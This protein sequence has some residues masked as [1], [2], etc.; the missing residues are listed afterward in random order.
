MRRREE[1]QGD[2]R[3]LA[4]KAS[5]E[6]QERLLC[7]MKRMIIGHQDDGRLSHRPGQLGEVGDGLIALYI[8]VIGRL[9][10]LEARRA[11]LLILGNSAP[12]SSIEAPLEIDKPLSVIAHR[13]G[14]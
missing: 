3:A 5:G 13:R 12:I 10:S 6:L 7:E 1:F 8:G 11:D 4:A 9:V 2:R 14:G